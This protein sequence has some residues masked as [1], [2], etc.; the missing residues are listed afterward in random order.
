MSIDSAATEQVV[1]GE[2]P[3]PDSQPLPAAKDPPEPVTRADLQILVAEHSSLLA[4][5]ALAWNES[6]S[7]RAYSWQLF[8]VPSWPA[9][10]PVRDPVSGALRGATSG[11]PAARRLRAPCYPGALAATSWR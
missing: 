9:R 8:R 3:A 6:S 2:T 10:W 1:P 5:R 4:S 11:S 7:G